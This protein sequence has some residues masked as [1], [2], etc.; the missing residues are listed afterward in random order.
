MTGE[1]MTGSMP[2]SVADSEEQVFL[3]SERFAASRLAKKNASS[4]FFDLCLLIL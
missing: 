4:F 1:D 2:F 3:S